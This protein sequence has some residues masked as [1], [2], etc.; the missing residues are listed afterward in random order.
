MGAYNRGSQVGF[1]RKTAQ[2]LKVYSV[3]RWH[4][5]GEGFHGPRLSHHL[6]KMPMPMIFTSWLWLEYNQLPKASVA[7]TFLRTT[8]S[9]RGYK[10]HQTLPFPKLFLLCWGGS[11]IQMKNW[12]GMLAWYWDNE[13]YGES[14]RN[15]F[16]ELNFSKP[17]FPLQNFFDDFPAGCSEPGSSPR[18]ILS[19]SLG[20]IMYI[21]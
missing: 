5:V 15:F 20:D 3:A 1:L 8:P 2:P 10:L 12:S 6:Q 18:E 13:G 21:F 16:G 11:L 9:D 4:L 17:F 14:L 7:M 19:D